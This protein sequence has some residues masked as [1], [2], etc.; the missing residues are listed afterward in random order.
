MAQSSEREKS[1]FN[2]SGSFRRFFTKQTSK[3][4]EAGIKD[5]QPVQP[6]INRSEISSIDIRKIVVN[7]DQFVDS[8]IFETKE[9]DKIPERIEDR[10]LE[11]YIPAANTDRLAEF[12]K[13]GLVPGVLGEEEMNFLNLAQVL[14]IRSLFRIEALRNNPKLALQ[15]FGVINER[16]QDPMEGPPIKKA[17]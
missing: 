6:V 2:P 13:K 14:Q 5:F 1:S 7:S 4:S 12:Y 16:L 17:I 10:A 3:P 9:I 8:L 11:R 15:F